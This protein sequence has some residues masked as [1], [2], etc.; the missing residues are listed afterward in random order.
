[1]IF[2]E[3][4]AGG[5]STMDRIVARSLETELIAELVEK[6]LAELEPGEPPIEQKKELVR[7][8][9]IAVTDAMRGHLL[10]SA[11]I[12]TK[13]SSI[14]ISSHPLFGTSR[15]RMQKVAKVLSSQLW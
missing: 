14:M 2:N 7:N 3:F 11:Q 8:Q 6:W 12:K 4:Y 13:K 15:P 5:T 9:A 1:M 10:H